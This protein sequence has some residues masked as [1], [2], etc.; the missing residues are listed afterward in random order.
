MTSTPMNEF[1]TAAEQKLSGLLS[2]AQN[3]SEFHA[4]CQ[5]FDVFISNSQQIFNAPNPLPA[6]EI[7]RL[8][9]LQR[10]ITTIELV[11]RNNAALVSDMPDYVDQSLSGLR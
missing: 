11:A 4:Q 8:K 1:L 5:D 10:K 9:S 2:C 7:S 6:D 3:A